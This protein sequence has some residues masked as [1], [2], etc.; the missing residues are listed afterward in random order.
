MVE[1]HPNLGEEERAMLL[2]S[3]EDEQ[4]TE[5]RAMSGDK[6]QATASCRKLL[7]LPHTWGIVLSASG[8]SRVLLVR[9]LGTEPGCSEPGPR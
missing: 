2:K 6:N 4:H 9:G 3:R 8:L 7:S 5:A 1:E